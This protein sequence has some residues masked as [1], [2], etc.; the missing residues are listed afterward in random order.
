MSSSSGIDAAQAMYD[1]AFA[2][3]LDGSP[4]VR[5][6]LLRIAQR[7]VL[8]DTVRMDYGADFSWDTFDVSGL[9]DFIEK[10]YEVHKVAREAQRPFERLWA[11]AEADVRARF[12]HG[13]MRSL[14][15]PGRR[16]VSD[17]VNARYQELLAASRR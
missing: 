13:G 9:C 8:L 2:L 14:N 7:M 17:A 4:A 12:A 11:Q 6:A 3:C 10:A 5:G 15:R 16:E 1:E